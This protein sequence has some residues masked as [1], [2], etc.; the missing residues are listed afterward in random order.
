MTTGFC[1]ACAVYV[2]LM[3]RATVPDSVST[4]ISMGALLGLAGVA[5]TSVHRGP[6]AP[7]FHYP[8]PS[9]HPAGAVTSPALHGTGLPAGR[10]NAPAGFFF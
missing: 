7:T 9:G 2:P 1:R 8:R 6:R 10:S 5:S 4:L 3:L